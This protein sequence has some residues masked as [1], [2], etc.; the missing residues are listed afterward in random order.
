MSF[1]FL[2]LE[3]L[4]D[5]RALGVKYVLWI[6]VVLGFSKVFYDIFDFFRYNGFYGFWGHLVVGV[7]RVL[8]F[9]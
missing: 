3:V 7:F 8:D 5:L 4:I 6:F 2:K 9:F 1:S